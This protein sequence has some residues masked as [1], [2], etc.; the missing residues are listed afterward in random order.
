MHNRAPD[1]LRAHAHA[2]ETAWRGWN[3]IALALVAALAAA[4]GALVAAVVLL[5]PS[6]VLP[7]TVASLML[8]AAT[9]ALIAWAAPPEAGRARIL[10]WDIAGALTAIGVCAALFGEPGEAVALLERDR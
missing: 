5:P 1:V 10:F 9:T 6:Q 7:A 2:V 4:A 8:A 3:G